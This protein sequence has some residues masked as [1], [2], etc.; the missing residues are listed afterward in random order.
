MKKTVV[1]FL[2]SG[3]GSNFKKVAEEILKGNIDAEIGIVISDKS[4][5]KALQTASDLSI[6]Y[7]IIERKK[8][9]VKKD[10]EKAMLKALKEVKTSLVITAGYMRILS[11]S[12]IR[13]YPNKIINIHP[14]LLPAFPGIRAQLQALNY[15]AKISGC[16]AHF[17]DEGTDTGPIILQEAVTI[18]SDDT[19]STLSKKILEL[20]HKILPLAIKLFCEKKILVKNRTV[21][22]K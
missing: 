20:E 21:L 10:H 8:Y 3:R 9:P 2:V 7:Q 5:A 17:I 19:E 4:Q 22:I 11:P 13:A 12:F 18:Q 16:T 14:S 6:K 1:S 15:G